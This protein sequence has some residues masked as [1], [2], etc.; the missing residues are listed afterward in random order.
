MQKIQRA[1]VD[2]LRCD[3]LTPAQFDVL[4]QVG[5]AEGLTQQE[6]AAALLVTKGNV[7]QLL[8][9]MEHCGLIRRQ[10]VGR[11]NRVYLTEAG[12][13]LRSRVVPSHERFI[14]SQFTALSP[15]EQRQLLAFL[16]R[17]D[18]ALPA[19]S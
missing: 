11:S 1:A 12:R 5:V 15:E 19:S 14:M 17:L 6:L 4:A 10:Q 8:D 9:R 2:D 3:V 7:T 16:R 18:R 13:A